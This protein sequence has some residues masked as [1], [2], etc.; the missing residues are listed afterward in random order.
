MA[1]YTDCYE[2]LDHRAARELLAAVDGPM[3]IRLYP[4]PRHRRV[5]PQRSPDSPQVLQ[6]LQLIDR[7]I[8]AAM[9]RLHEKGELDDT[10]FVLV[11]DHGATKMH[12]HLD[13]AQWF[14]GARRADAAPSG[15]VDP[16]P[17][18]GGHGGRQ[19]VRVDLRASRR[20]AHRAPGPW[21]SCVVPRRSAPTDDIVA[22]LVRE[23]AVA[24]VAAED[25]DGNVRVASSAGEAIITRDEDS[26]RYTLLSGDPLELGASFAGDR[27]EWLAH[28]FDSPYPDAA[29]HLL[30]QF[31]SPRGGDL[32]VVGTRGLRLPRPVRDSGAQVGAR[33][34]DPRAHA[35]AAVDQP[36]AAAGT[37]CAPPTS[38]RRCSTGSTCR[39]RMASTDARCGSRDAPRVSRSR[40]GGRGRARAGR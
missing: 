40:A 15:G 11:S 25:G 16:E 22:A 3:A 12:T 19:C 24:F 13:L 21:S 4:V 39:C 20:A 38:S 37:A 30:D 2:P 31:S 33:Q 14:I 26:I 32:V 35:Y 34:P 9:A 17:A 27:D 36:S 1:H 10:L 29:V 7:S 23:P 18:R 8:G 28:T 6:S 5:H